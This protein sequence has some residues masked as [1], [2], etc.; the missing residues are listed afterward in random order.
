MIPPSPP[1]FASRIAPAEWLL[2]A[3]A[4]LLAWRF[5]LPQFT[6][7]ARTYFLS[8]YI[9]KVVPFFAD[10]TGGGLIDTWALGDPRPRLVT[11]V[12]QFINFQFRGAFPEL[13]AWHPGIGVAW[14]LYPLV[15]WQVYRT[16]RLLG[17]DH[18]MAAAAALLWASSPPALDTLV[19]CYLPAK[20]LMNLWF[21]LA[22]RLAA[23]IAAAQAAG[24]PPDRRTQLLLGG[25]VLLA[26]LTDETSAVLVVGVLLLFV[27][28]FLGPGARPR[29]RLLGAGFIL[30]GLCFGLITFLAF[31]LANRIAGQVPLNY[32]DLAVHGPSS[33]MTG[34]KQTAAPASAH[35]T[36]MVGKVNPLYLGFVAASAHLLP[37]RAVPGYWTYS[38][39]LAPSEW[40]ILE[41][42]SLILVFAVLVALA[43]RLPG[44]GKSFALRCGFALI[45]IVIV[46]SLLL[47]PLAPAILEINYYGA[48]FS[49]PLALL[50]AI[51]LLG[52]V[53][54][55]VG[56]CAAVLWVA[57][58]AWLQATGYEQTNRRTQVYFADGGLT[59][60]H[61][62]GPAWNRASA[63]EIK[64][65]V[66]EGRFAEVIAQYRFP[67]PGFCLAFEL[68]AA[69][70]HRAG[71]KADYLPGESADRPFALMLAQQWQWLRFL[72]INLDRLTGLTPAIALAQ[73]ARPVAPE[74]WGDLIR[75]TSW[76]GR[77]DDWEFTRVFDAGGEFAER[78]WLS[79]ISRVW[80]QTGT[81][82]FASPSPRLT[83]TGTRYNNPELHTLYLT[84]D[85]EYLA[86]DQAGR[87]HLR[88]RLIAPTPL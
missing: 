67:S 79:S 81:V 4:L 50:F 63:R 56:R 83:F 87:C 86:F 59:G 2:G 85:N 32:W 52:G 3:A 30:P 64:Q 62:T 66:D 46:Y 22:I 61:P 11:L 41:T 74:T 7:V 70:E 25:V 78:Y 43:T 72:H 57:A 8:E 77:G 17:G 54:T 47:V 37:F 1:R 82:R 68:A 88:F 76:H 19:L 13:A 12:A 58:V 24:Q 5:L 15:L 51:V 31:P 80:R 39:P 29:G 40:P 14:L 42:A 20:A 18:L 44:W 28:L 69:R 71:R 48:L 35:F 65:G 33:A 36:D 6:D 73:G 53:Q 60:G 23:Q 75:N 45:G 34:L 84:A 38:R 10:A 16:V 49:L 26:L 27:P 9:L 55:P 21:A